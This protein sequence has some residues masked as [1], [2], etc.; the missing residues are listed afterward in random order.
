MSP[1]KVSVGEEGEGHSMSIFTRMPGENY[2]RRLRSLLF[3]SCY[4]LRALNNSL[5][6]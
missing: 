1:E 4:I 3:Y 5:V 6:C 2:S